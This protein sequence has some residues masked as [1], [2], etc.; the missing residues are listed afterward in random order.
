MYCGQHFLTVF[1]T[2]KFPAYMPLLPTGGQKCCRICLSHILAKID[3]HEI[4][5]YQEPVE[6]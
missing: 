4:T 3:L 2:A 5:Y 1:T 6:I